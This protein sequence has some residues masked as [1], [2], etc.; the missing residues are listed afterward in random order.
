M[1]LLFRHHNCISPRPHS[2]VYLYERRHSRTAIWNRACCYVVTIMWKYI[3]A[4]M[5]ECRSC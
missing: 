3:F 1:A 2:S 5:I 4:S